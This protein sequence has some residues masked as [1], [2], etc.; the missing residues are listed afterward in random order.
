MLSQLNTWPMFSPVNT[1][2]L[3]SRVAAH[4]SG[5]GWLARPFPYGTFTRYSLPALP[6]VLSAIRPNASREVRNVGLDIGVDQILP[7]T[8]A[9]FFPAFSVTRLTASSLPLRER[10]SRRCKAWCQ[11]RPE[12]A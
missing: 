1:S 7:S 11:R 3:P 12:I 10:V 8:P 5:P 9:V 4:D 6:G 2:R